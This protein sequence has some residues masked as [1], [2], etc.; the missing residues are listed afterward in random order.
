MKKD[1]EKK[2]CD[3]KNW[4]CAGYKEKEGTYR[5]TS[6]YEVYCKDCRNFVNLLNGEII[7][8]KGLVWV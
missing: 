4:R 2:K 5:V 8:D 1:T 3:Q 6:I 7:N